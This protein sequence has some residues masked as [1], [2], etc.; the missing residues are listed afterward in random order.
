VA[1]STK[2]NINRNR[3]V[4]MDDINSELV[5]LNCFS[6]AESGMLNKVIIINMIMVMVPQKK[7]INIA[8]FLRIS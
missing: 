2:I 8:S 3:K 5:V 7:E 1:A 4:G 6:K